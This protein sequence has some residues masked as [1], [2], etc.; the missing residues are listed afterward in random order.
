M[1]KAFSRLDA[2]WWTRAACAGLDPDWWT[3]QTETQCRVLAVRTCLSC[4]VRGDCLTEA[5]VAGD[6]GVI[7]AGMLLI[8]KG[9]R[10]RMVSLVCRQ[11]GKLP[12]CARFGTRAGY[13]G[14]RCRREADAA[15]PDSNVAA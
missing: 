13:C 2:R 14:V 11:C 3:E 9:N 6:V 5:I 7:R 12:V 4:P 15:Q 10:Q 8:Q 1:A